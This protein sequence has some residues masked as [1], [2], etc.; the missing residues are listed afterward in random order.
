MG[1]IEETTETIATDEGMSEG[2]T[3]TP[4]TGEGEGAELDED[5]PNTTLDT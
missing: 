1:K 5:G 4:T 2:S 3:K